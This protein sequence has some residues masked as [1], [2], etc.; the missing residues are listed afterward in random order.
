MWWQPKFSFTFQF[1]FS[2]NNTFTHRI[3]YFLPK[4]N[5]SIESFLYF[6]PMNTSNVFY[7]GIAFL[8]QTFKFC[9]KWFSAI[10]FCYTQIPTR[11]L[12]ARCSALLDEAAIAEKRAALT[13]DKRIT[14]FPLILIIEWLVTAFLQIK[15]CVPRIHCL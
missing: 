5:D 1:G 2:T 8:V 13:V 12:T 4:K 6:H 14:S 9:I 15:Y 11:L 7:I 10:C 3:L